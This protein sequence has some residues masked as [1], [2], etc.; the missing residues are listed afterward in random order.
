MFEKLNL[1]NEVQSQHTPVAFIS[2]DMNIS[3]KNNLITQGI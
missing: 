2:E 3:A 1:K